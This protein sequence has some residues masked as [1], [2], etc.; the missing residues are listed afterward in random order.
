MNSA[1]NTDS[2]IH[3]EIRGGCDVCVQNLR[4]EPLPAAEMQPTVTSITRRCVRLG[5]LSGRSRFVV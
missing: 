2:P 3:R 4:L 5:F 1:A